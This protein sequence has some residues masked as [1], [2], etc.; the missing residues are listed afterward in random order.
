MD[1]LTNRLQSV[2]EAPPPA[3]ENLSTPRMTPA[4]SAAKFRRQVDE[5]AWIAECRRLHPWFPLAR[6]A[7]GKALPL[8]W[9]L[10]GF[11]PAERERLTR[12]Q[13]AIH[14]PRWKKELTPALSSW[15]DAIGA[16][17]LPSPV[18]ALEA[19]A[20]GYLLPALAKED[21]TDLSARLLT[22]LIALVDQPL[23]GDGP[24]QILTQLWLKI[25]LPLV[26]AYFTTDTRLANSFRK[27]AIGAEARLAAAGLDSLSFPK[28]NRE[29]LLRPWLAALVR[30]K[31]LLRGSEVEFS[32]T[33]QERLERLARNVLRL[34]RPAGSSILQTEPSTA[35][36][37]EFLT[38]A[39]VAIPHVQ[40]LAA[41]ALG[42]TPAKPAAKADAKLLKGQPV[43][44]QYSAV[45]SLAILRNRWS[46]PPTQA[47]VDFSG[48]QV[49]L[50]LTC[51]NQPLLHG[52]LSTAIRVDEQPLSPASGWTE[53]CWHSDADCDYLE[54]EQKLS[55]GW[56]LQRHL[57]LVRRDESLLLADSILSENKLPPQEFLATGSNA[58]RLEYSTSLPFAPGVSFAPQKETREGHLQGSPTRKRKEPSEV[59]GTPLALVLPLALPEWRKQPCP[60]ELTASEKSL[61]HSLRATGR[62]LF[63]PLWLD[64]NP[65]RFKK[66]EATWRQLTVGES[67]AIQPR[68]VAV[69]Y[70]VQ[71]HYSQFLLYRSLAWRGNRTVLGKNFA[72]DFACCR[73]HPNGEVDE[74]LEV[75]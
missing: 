49:W 23:S 7:A 75:Q 42:K 66:A 38:A 4:D 35:N 45:S 10:W 68:E 17:E 13:Q 61:T 15:L 44:P 53:V 16:I 47:T 57:L 73:F 19:L 40:P 21:R 1:D 11:E 31:E 27:G 51:G 2:L 25:E 74:I 46:A 26:L 8:I 62:N 33:A 12:L 69:G 37:R 71:V 56:L 52:L 5:N 60:G 65:N 64:L 39:V 14:A 9:G 22:Q 29:R 72:T 6:I 59:A 28:Q 3:A 48:P 18:L 32:E 36:D 58:P 20:W 63:A 67:L 54:I 41:L 24:E 43:A 34:S 55:G 50:D 70:R 30:G